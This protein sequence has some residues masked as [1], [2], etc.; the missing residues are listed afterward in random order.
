MKNMKKSA[1]I[2]M[3]L[4]MIP[5]MLMGCK[6]KVAPD[7]TSKTLVE[8][9]IKGDQSGLSKIGVSQ[10]EINDAAKA[11]KDEFIKEI[12]SAFTTSGLNVT[13]AQVNEIYKAIIDDFKKVTVTSQIAS[14][15]DKTAEVKLKSTYFDLEGIFTK[16]ANNAVA[17]FENSGI[18]DER[19]LKT[20]VT[21]AYIK[22][23]I[24]ELKNAK[25]GEAKEKTFKF[26]I[27]DKVW[28]PENESQF[29]SDVA[30]LVSGQK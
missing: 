13:D 23:I 21:D 16:A 3:S 11:E 17:Q 22:N 27:K 20:K 10:T 24:A 18:T 26:V 9:A 1:A 12:K 14:Q 7:E 25:P 15:S 2:L 29:F 6:P 4:L 28:L 30:K 5:L 8:F 19:E